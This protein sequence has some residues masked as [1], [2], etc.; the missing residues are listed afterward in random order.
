MKKRWKIL[1][2]ILAVFVIAAVG[3]MMYLQTNLNKLMYEEIVEADLQNIEDGEYI[4]EYS[5]PPV[6]AKVQVE[7]MDGKIRDIVILEHGHGQGGPAEAIVDDVIAQQKIDVDSI[8][9]ATYSSRVILKAV[10]DALKDN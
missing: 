2:G 8:S 9:G 6:N 4:G 10:E 5:S 1:L 3:M 7:V